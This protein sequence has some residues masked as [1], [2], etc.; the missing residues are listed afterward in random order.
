LR[1]P[2]RINKKNTANPSFSSVA[3]KPLSILPASAANQKKKGKNSPLGELDAFRRRPPTQRPRRWRREHAA[4][5]RVVVASTRAVV[6]VASACTCT[7][8]SSSAFIYCITTPKSTI[9]RRRA[10][11]SQASSARTFPVLQTASPAPSGRAPARCRS[12]STRCGSARNRI[13]FWA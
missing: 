8:S 10:P 5:F 11:A 3:L 13:V 12:R 9:H 1:T 7:R 2:A 6:S 4:L